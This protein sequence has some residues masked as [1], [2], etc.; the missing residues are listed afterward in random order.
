MDVET[1][2]AEAF[3]EEW[4]QVVATLIRITGDWDLAE[5][6]AQEAF[7]LALRTWPRDGIPDRPGAW[8]TTAA[9]HRATDRLRRDALGAAKLREAARMP[10]PSPDPVPEPDDSGVTDDRLRLIFTCCH[11]ALATEAQVALAL[12]TLAGLSTAEI[13]RAFLVP[14]ATMSQ[15]LVRVKRKI[16]HARIP[17][18]VPP[19][20][21][22][23]ERTNAVLGVLYLTFSE[24][25]SASAG[26][27]LLRPDLAAEALRLAR[28]L[29]QLMPD[30]PEALGLL[31]LM[32]LQHARRATRVDAE[33]VLVP[34]E[35]QDRTRWDTAAITE[36]TAVLETALRRR[37]PGPYQIQAAIA[38][39][40]AIAARAAD[41][42]WP[43][44]A[45]LYDQLRKH[46]P[47]AVVEL[48]RAIAVG[49][50]HGPAAGLALLDAL[51]LPDY[52]LLAAARADF[53][54]RLGRHAEARHWYEQARD[55]AGTDAE[56]SY[57][58]RRISETVSVPGDAVR[59]AGEARPPEEHP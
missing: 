18:R 47:S 21:L 1:V 10:V 52:H 56:R 44:I 36:G 24:G 13:A 2:V 27:D 46:V 57:L 48:N 20:H 37:R 3:R 33:G 31:A 26:P 35:E 49:M 22:L 4:G 42:D 54:R 38:A 6:C 28:V 32:L 50:A 41:T 34:L 11:P 17:Y 40:H 51:A 16:R 55:L 39:C 8:L 29:A 5:E 43:Q 53:L 15:R 19:A 30:E 45:G 23:P 14:E 9:R 58:T 25:Y 12:R 59:R 7:A